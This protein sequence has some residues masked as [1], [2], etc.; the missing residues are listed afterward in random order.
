MELRGSALRRRLLGSQ[1]T[2]FLPGLDSQEGEACRL[3][4]DCSGKF[5]SCCDEF[6]LNPGCQQ[7]CIDDAED[8][9]N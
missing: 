9:E 7:L 3:A 6:S 4:S 5:D 2:N 8:D 1:T